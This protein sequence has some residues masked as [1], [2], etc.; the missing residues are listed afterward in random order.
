ML[1]HSLVGEVIFISLQHLIAPVL[2]TKKGGNKLKLVK[3]ID[4]VIGIQNFKI[5]NQNWKQLKMLNWLRP[6]HL[7]KWC[8]LLNSYWTF[9]EGKT[10]FYLLGYL[11]DKKAKFDL[12]LTKSFFFKRPKTLL[13]HFLS[14]KK[15]NCQ[16]Q[17]CFFGTLS[18]LPLFGTIFKLEIWAKKSFNLLNG[19]VILSPFYFSFKCQF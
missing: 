9:F 6:Q 5:C 8:L 13:W 17:I 12:R 7:K 10:T 18:F 4:Q 2:L 11:R 19:D 16:K 15:R 14:P 3:N 1:Q